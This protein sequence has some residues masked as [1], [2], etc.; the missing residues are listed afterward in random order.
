M[1]K[2]VSLFLI[3]V[4]HIDDQPR[5][6]MAGRAAVEKPSRVL[7]RDTHRLIGVDARRGDLIEELGKILGHRDLQDDERA[8]AEEVS[9]HGGARLNQTSSRRL[10]VGIETMG[11]WFP[12]D[13][14]R[15]LVGSTAAI[16]RAPTERQHH[17]DEPGHIPALAP[18]VALIRAV[19]QGGHG[20]VCGSSGGRISLERRL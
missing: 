1:S 3:R 12:G 9:G 16:Y 5:L 8:P 4:E 10:L 19:A 7:Q 11:V 6:A 18:S 14:R 2:K 20:A 15:R 17:D 13:Q